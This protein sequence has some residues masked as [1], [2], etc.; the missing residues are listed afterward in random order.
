MS[1]NAFQKKI[2]TYTAQNSNYPIFLHLCLEN[3]DMYKEFLRLEGITPPK[4]GIEAMIDEAT[5]KDKSVMLDFMD[6]VF[7]V[8]DGRVAA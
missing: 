6:F 2:T 1:D 4:N 7:E 5:G 3:E 8:L